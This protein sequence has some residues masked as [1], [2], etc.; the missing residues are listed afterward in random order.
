[1][2]HLPDAHDRTPRRPRGLLAWQAAWQLTGLSIWLLF[3]LLRLHQ[4]RAVAE[5]ANPV[6]WLLLLVPFAASITAWRGYRFAPWP[7]RTALAVGSALLSAAALLL[8]ILL[9]GTPIHLALGGRL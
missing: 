4:E 6:S 2:V 5:L 1:M 3:E 7:A 9:V 8:L